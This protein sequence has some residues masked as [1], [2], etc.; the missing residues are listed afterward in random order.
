MRLEMRHLVVQRLVMWV[1]AMAQHNRPS[2][3]RK[4]RSNMHRSRAGKIVHAELV[5]P[6]V[7]VPFKVCEDVIDEGRPTE[8]EKHGGP[9]APALQHCAC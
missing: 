8:Q 5:E 7:G 2:Q 3:R 6:A 4:A 9:Q 1:L